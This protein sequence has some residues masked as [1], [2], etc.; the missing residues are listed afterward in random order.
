MN[1][2]YAFSTFLGGLIFALLLQLIWDKL[3]EKLG[4]LGGFL[5]AMLIPGSM[6]IINHGMNNHLIM[7]SNSIW[8]DMSWAAAI[9]GVT[10]TKLTGKS[11]KESIPNIFAAII[12]GILAGFIIIILK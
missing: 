3:V 12:G 1:F 10:V 11:I 9:G 4:I 7:Q 8:I 6:W 5:S 2:Y